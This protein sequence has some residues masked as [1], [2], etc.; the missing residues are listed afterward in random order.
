MGFAGPAPTIPLLVLDGTDEAY[1]LA[2][3]QLLQPS[4]CELDE[5]VVVVESVSIKKAFALPVEVVGIG[6]GDGL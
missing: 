3:D 5:D 1:E 2:E 4:E 6:E